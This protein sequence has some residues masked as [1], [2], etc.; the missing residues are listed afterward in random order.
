MYCASR[1]S[2]TS[3]ESDASDMSDKSVLPA[4]K[5][6]PYAYPVSPHPAGV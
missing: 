2:D 5:S 1:S 6:M 3:D 4:S